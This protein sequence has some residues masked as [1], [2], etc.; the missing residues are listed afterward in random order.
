VGAW[1]VFASGTL[2]DDQR[3]LVDYAIGPIWEANLGWMI[4]VVVLL[5]VCVPLAFAA[6]S[7]ALHIPLTVM[8]V[9]VVLRGS[10]FAFLHAYTH[11]EHH[12]PAPRRWARVFAVASLVT[13]LTL[14]V[15]LGALSTG[16][17]LDPLTRRVRTDFFSEWL[18]PFPFAVGLF[19]LLLFAFLAAVYLADEAREDPDLS[20]MF[21]R[22]ALISAG[23]VAAA[24]LL[25]FL[26]APARLQAGLADTPWAVALHVTTGLTAIAAI[27]L[28]VRRRLR[29]AR[30]A[31][32]LQ[33]ALIVIGWALA[34]H[35]HLAWPHL[36]I[37]AAAAPHSVLV[38]VLV[39]LGLGGV[40]LIPALAYLFVVFKSR[41][42][43]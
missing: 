38:P 13:P 43:G 27:V 8:L 10:A 11:A 24:A 41:R 19:T 7:T 1:L 31:A 26:V 40:L 20:D 29:A 42:R 2:S 9:G 36:T 34:Q 4:L 18:A 23:L 16:L 25:T 12:D 17:E 30:L 15:T 32:M 6:I 39:A 22:R 14:G 3:D 33:I 35:P 5:F 37:T 21:R 28:L